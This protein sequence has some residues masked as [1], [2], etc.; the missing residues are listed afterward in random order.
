MK[1]TYPVPLTA[2]QISNMIDFIETTFIVSIRED[3]DIDNID[4][5]MDMMDA[6]RALRRTLA[7]IPSEESR[8]EEGSC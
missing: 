1:P 2:S 5:V 3:T 4:Y 8:V 6:L 7:E